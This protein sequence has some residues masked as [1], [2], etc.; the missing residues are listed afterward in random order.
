MPAPPTQAAPTEMQ[1]T[2]FPVQGS[3]PDGEQTIDVGRHRLAL[4]CSGTGS[5]TVI[6]EAG[7]GGDHTSWDVVQPAIAQET[8]VCSYDRA[9]M[10]QSEAGTPPYTAEQTANDLHTLL[11]NASIAPPYL[12]VGH[13]FG[14][15][16][17]RE[18]A[19][20]FP[21]DVRGMVFV[22]AVHEDWWSAAAALLPPPGPQDSP[23]RAV[24]PRLS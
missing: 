21:D 10:G 15:L 5:P 9:G 4:Y 2:A 20:L 6:L 18:Y 12:L 3:S 19:H 13:S 1:A 14:G 17:I 16:F 11:T 22:D 24:V 7:L 8:R 23:A